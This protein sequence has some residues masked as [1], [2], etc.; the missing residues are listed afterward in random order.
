MKLAMVAADYTPGEADQLRRDM[1]AW[2]R[3]GRI[4]RHRERL[5]SRMGAKGIAEE[6]AERVF[7]QIQG[8]G[9]YGFP[10]SHAASF[11]LIS[12]A[13]AW[14]KCHY[15]AEFTCALLNAQ[16]MGFYSPATII[17]DAKRH[18]IEIRPVSV[19]ESEWE[20]TLEPIGVERS[21]FGVGRE[22]TGDSRGNQESGAR[23]QNERPECPTAYT[24]SVVPRGS[25]L[26]SEFCILDSELLPPPSRLPPSF[27][28]R[29]GLRYVNGLSR[30]DYERIRAAREAAPFAS[31]EDLMAR[32]ALDRGILAVLAQA[33]GLEP[34]TP[35]RRE[36]LWAVLG[37]GSPRNPQSAIRNHGPSLPV[38]QVEPPASF[39]RLTPLETVLWDY[40]TQSHSARAHPLAT[41]RSAFR[42]LGFPTAAEV[43]AMGHGRHVR[44]AGLVICRQRP[45]TA[46]GVTFLTLED[47][48]GFVN[49]VVWQ[50]VYARHMVLVKTV[51]LL[52]VSGRLQV[53]DRVAHLIARTFWVPEV[54]LRGGH[55]PSRDFH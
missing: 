20:C 33:G 13:T 49:V 30:K 8:F 32:T 23:S 51:P 12:Y 42:A 40:R 55:G 48:T 35:P 37:G 26:N 31:V 28:V 19:T 50:H 53:E 16:P 38:A 17:E 34:L 1:A 3:G 11:A 18:R 29:I 21:A 6:F 4:G 22:A 9:E 45:G 27:A 47:E 24:E 14:L 5:I 2:R 52:G 7:Q 46:R 43:E 10:E 39:S 54:D 25:L 36:A 41:V 44:Y 15:P